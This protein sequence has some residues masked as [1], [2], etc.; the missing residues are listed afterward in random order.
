VRQT[1]SDRVRRWRDMR[2]ANQF[3]Q[4]TARCRETNP[5]LTSSS[6]GRRSPEA[7]ASRRVDDCPETIAAAT[8]FALRHQASAAACV[9]TGAKSADR[10]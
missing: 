2:G 6:A 4:T 8:C 1:I 5:N 7:N 9:H 10:K 3:T